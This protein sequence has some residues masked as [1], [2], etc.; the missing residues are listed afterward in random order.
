[1]RV[2][3]LIRTS[4]A[5]PALPLA[6][7]LVVLYYFA[8]TRDRLDFWAVPHA[9]TLVQ[10]SIQVMYALSYALVSATAAWQG[11]RLT[12]A[13]V[14]HTAPCRPRWQIIALTLSPVVG[15][16]WLM[17]GTP[18]VLAF[19]Q[20]PTR[21][22]WDSLPPLLLGLLLCGAHALIGFT[23]GRWVKPLL[24]APGLASVVF[25]AVAFPHS[26]EPMVLRHIMGEYAVDLG[27]GESATAESLLAQLLPTAG[28]AGAVA[29]GWARFRPAAR[30]LL[31]AALVTASTGA[32]YTIAKDWDHNPS[33]HTGGVTT[34][35]R[36]T[37]PEVCMPEQAADSI[38]PV[39]DTIVRT[40]DLL[41]TYGVVDT[42]PKTVEDTM[43][44]GRFAPDSTDDTLYLPLA[45][46]HRD[47]RVE[48]AVIEAS[49]HFPCEAAD[50]T[51]LRAVSMW[52][53]KKLGHSTSYQRLAAGDPFYDRARHREL[54]ER[55]DRI[56]AQS[57]AEQ[58][59]WYRS[60]V[61]DACPGTPL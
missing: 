4:S 50:P 30:A 1:M 22:T 8:E 51:S 23:V 12:E 21:P 6:L 31:A 36:G 32:A 48:A 60:T 13:G 61:T 43:A 28:L 41:R 35:C 58:A 11:A 9:P 59:A 18:V 34:V 24:A 40:Y 16:G 19:M 7:G 17:L 47:H 5:L 46:A 33:I 15:L 37:D 44:H 42:P 29:L 56:S 39:R 10:Q 26:M 20:R 45:D 38:G 54:T 3:T 2:R 57:A 49:V 27:F 52:L 25:V 14:W 53:E 55:V